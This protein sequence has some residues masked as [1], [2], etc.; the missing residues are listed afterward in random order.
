MKEYEIRDFFFNA[1]STYGL[2]YGK[3]EL[4]VD[5]LRIDIFAI[6]KNHTPYII[7]FKKEKNRHIVGQAAQ[8]LSLIPTFD[9][10]IEKEINFYDIKWSKLM[11]LCVAPDFME[12]D[13][14]AAEYEPLKG[15]IH[16]YTFQVIKNSR[17]QIFSLNLEYNG[18]DENGPLTIPKKMVDKYDIKQISDE[19]Y[20]LNKKEA[21]REYYSKTILPLLNEIGNNIPEFSKYGLFQHNSY[22]DRWFT[23]RFGTDKEKAHRASI[24][25]SFSNTISLGFDLT[26][27]FEEGKY[28]S[29]IF[30]EKEK[31]KKFIKNT[32]KLKEYDLYIPNTGIG[33]WLPI[34]LISEK[35][36]KILLQ[37][38]NPEKNRDCYLRIMKEYGKDII[39][40]KKATDVLKEEY[41]KFKYIFELLKMRNGA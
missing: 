22:W 17:G 40:I 24:E 38:Y 23:L 4:S 11:V 9:E 25:L 31:L 33:A 12:R 14:K 34:K 26:H 19:F 30:G 8:Y 29:H 16:F 27:S 3:K 20:E 32:L 39:N 21:R 5:G 13:Y 6:D 18:P 41:G 28:L 2:K 35:G 7:E 1:L 10:K 36:L 37:S 15:K